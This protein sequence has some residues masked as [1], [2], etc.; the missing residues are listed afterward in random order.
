MA[1]PL[2]PKKADALRAQGRCFVTSNRRGAYDL[3]KFLHEAS[4]SLVKVGKAVQKLYVYWGFQ[5]WGSYL[6]NE[7]HMA[8]DEAKKLQ[9]VWEVF[10][11]RL[12]STWNIS[13]L[14]DTGR[15]WALVR[16]NNSLSA[17]NVETW[18]RRAAPL[19]LEEL[20]LTIREEMGH[21]GQL[22]NPCRNVH[23]EVHL[24]VRQYAVVT[25]VL[26]HTMKQHGDGSRGNA[27]FEIA[28]HYGIEQGIL[29]DE[30][31]AEEV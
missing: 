9:E 23:F 24:T 11:V 7:L 2:T 18:L 29:A 28:K 4:T 26:V 19:P 14:L 13:L 20:R 5:S 25:A 31:L 10:G 30:S 3:G 6:T 21:F 12:K 17:D 15:M 22:K 1:Q 27:L 8:W 16:L